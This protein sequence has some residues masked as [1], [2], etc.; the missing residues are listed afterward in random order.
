MKIGIIGAGFTGL[1]AAY[2]ISKAGENVSLFESEPNPGGLAAGFRVKGWEWALEEHYHHWFTSDWSVRNLAKEMGHEVKFFRPKTS[3]LIRDGIFQLD[4]P[5]SL[6]KFPYLPLLDRIRTGAV[7]AYLK[8]TPFWKMLEGKTAESYLRKT[9]GDRSWDI[10]WKPLFV[11]KFGNY[12][13]S[14]PASWFWARIKKRSASLGYPDGGFGSFAN[15]ICKRIKEMN[16]EIYFNSN[17]VSVLKK[18]NRFLLTL[19][20]GK[21]LEFD[22]IICTLPSFIFTKI[23]YDLP[24]SYVSSL[25]TLKSLSAITLILV[26]KEKFLKDGTYW[27]NVNDR[28]YPFLAVVEHTNFID[29]KYYNGERIIYIGNYLPQDH[30]YL[31]YSKEKLIETFLPYLKRINNKFSK[32][33]IINSFL[34][35]AK[36]AQPIIPL[37]YSKEIP[38]MVTPI[39]GLYLANIQQV[40]PWDRGTNYAVELGNKVADL[41][42]K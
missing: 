17:I 41:V 15:S 3:V 26:I 30:E 20:D 19:S 1:S 18:D 7:L 6:L 13:S 16:G 2:R 23:T 29:P 24:K 11:G 31:D 38:S 9:M 33:W 36:Y 5:F 22:K 21:S 14:I 39:D 25:K 28:T 12:A 40:Y 4:S 42:L 37:N 34:F 8:M 32:F 35:S 27:I 10:I